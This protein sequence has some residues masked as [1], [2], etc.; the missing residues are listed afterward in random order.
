MLIVHHTLTFSLVH[1]AAVYAP[2]GPDGLERT[3]ANR[4]GIWVCPYITGNATDQTRFGAKS[5]HSLCRLCYDLRQFIAGVAPLALRCVPLRPEKPQFC[6]V[7]RGE[8]GSHRIF[9]LDIA[10]VGLI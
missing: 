3:E 1:I 7:H 5:D 6:P 10:H 9:T 2:V 8:T 4:A